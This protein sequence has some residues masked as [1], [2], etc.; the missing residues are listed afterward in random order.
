[1][2]ICSVCGF[3]CEDETIVCP[4]CGKN[5]DSSDNQPI[6]KEPDPFEKYKEIIEK[7]M[8]Q[9]QAEIHALKK[10]LEKPENAEDKAKRQKDPHDFTDCFGK[11]DVE[12][13][14][15]FAAFTYLGGIAGI[16]LNMMRDRS[17]P[18]LN[19]HLLQSL[20]LLCL[21][22][23]ILICAFVLCWTVAVPVIALVLILVLSIIRLISAFTV[24]KGL[25]KEAYIVRGLAFLDCILPKKRN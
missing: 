10:S 13:N 24:F 23:I 3:E 21:E 7:Q 1:M 12:E 5:C 22:A 14:R 4:E 16:A 25:S 17:S 6:T 20:K 15:L 11:D 19:F 9:Q 18:Y 8:K 2:K